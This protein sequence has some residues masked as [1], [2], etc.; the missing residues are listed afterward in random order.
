[1]CVYKSP[2]LDWWW[3]LGVVGGWTPEWAKVFWTVFYQG[4]IL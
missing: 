3:G 4:A 1:M 2:A